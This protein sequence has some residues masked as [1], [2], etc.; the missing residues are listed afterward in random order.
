M[1]VSG[2]ASTIYQPSPPYTGPEEAIGHIVH[3]F[4]LLR[5]DTTQDPY[6]WRS[7]APRN[8]TDQRPDIAVI[9]TTGG[10]RPSPFN[11]PTDTDP[12]RRLQYRSG[13]YVIG[14]TGLIKSAYKK[15]ELKIWGASSVSIYGRVRSVNTCEV[16]PF[17]VISTRETRRAKI[18]GVITMTASAS[19]Q[20]DSG[21]L[22]THRGDDSRHVVGMLFAGQTYGSYVR[23]IPAQ[24]IK[25]VLERAGKP[26]SHYWGTARDNRKPSTRS[27]DG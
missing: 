13:K 17:P 16:V 27:N 6:C 21:A 22:I 8:N 15:N 14:P 20:G 25:D 1:F 26:F 5:C 10:L 3:A 24:D 18:C 11:N 2:S 12:I 7:S 23:V 4:T 9:D 19:R